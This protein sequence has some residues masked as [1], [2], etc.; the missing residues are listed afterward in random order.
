MDI[1]VVV[2]EISKKAEKQWALEK[3][4]NEMQEKVKKIDLE[5]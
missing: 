1:R 4:L 3:K 5:V 2:E